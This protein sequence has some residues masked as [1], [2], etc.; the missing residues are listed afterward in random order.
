MLG[1]LLLH[2]GTTI[3][4][5]FCYL[6]EQSDRDGRVLHGGPFGMFIQVEQCREDVLKLQKFSLKRAVFGFVVRAAES[7]GIQIFMV[8]IVIPR[9]ICRFRCLFPL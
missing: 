2:I 7:L 1:Q 8:I 9:I 4:F 5:S 6:L 3:F